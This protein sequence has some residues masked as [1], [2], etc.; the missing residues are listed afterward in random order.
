MEEVI[1][2]ENELM[3]VRSLKSEVMKQ[4]IIN[5]ES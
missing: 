1:N 3:D 2:L 5:F 4:K